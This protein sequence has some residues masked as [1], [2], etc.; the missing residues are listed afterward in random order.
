M[1][2]LRDE[3]SVA[4]NVLIKGNPK[5]LKENMLEK[6]LEDSGDLLENCLLTL[7]KTRTF[8][9]KNKRA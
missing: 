2:E 4:V 5:I 3:N 1:L 6:W 7:T 8:T 9:F